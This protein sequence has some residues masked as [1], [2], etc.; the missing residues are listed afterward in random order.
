VIVFNDAY[1]RV[2]E[3]NNQNDYF[4]TPY[5]YSQT[6]KAQFQYETIF[7]QLTEVAGQM[8]RSGKLTNYRASRKLNCSAA[9]L[10]VSDRLIRQ[11]TELL[12]NILPRIQGALKHGL[13]EICRQSERQA[14]HSFGRSKLTMRFVAFEKPVVTPGFLYDEGKFMGLSDHR[15]GYT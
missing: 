7:P 15:V 12:S 5:S 2:C 11:V 14:S 8:R 6:Y 9:K 13:N 3:Y 1:H 4:R 10:S